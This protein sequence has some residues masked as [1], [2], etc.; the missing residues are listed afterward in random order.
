MID[1]F[2]KT[3]LNPQNDGS[4]SHLLF[5]PPGVNGIQNVK[6]L[7]EKHFGTEAHPDLM[8]L[9]N[10]QHKVDD[11]RDTRTFLQSKPFGP[12]KIMWVFFADGMNE[13]SSNAFLKS[14]EEPTPKTHIILSTDRPEKI[15]PT[16]RSRCQVT[17][18]V[19]DKKMMADEMRDHGVDDKEMKALLEQTGGHVGT[20]IALTK[21]KDAKTWAKSVHDWINNR[22]RHAKTPKI[23]TTG[24]SGLTARQCALV[25]Q[26]A[27]AK[28]LRG[29]N[30]PVVTEHFQTWI[31]NNS[32]IDRPGLDI[33]TRIQAWYSLFT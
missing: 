29:Q 19:S 8:I 4:S 6:P 30:N 10:P 23:P 18:F 14:L 12:L 26:A 11:I 28:S 17:S 20:A 1:D 21:V 27:L 31:E 3:L 9:E 13:A 25:F 32:D 7:L 2:L 22:A 33:K 15:L 16:I 5:L 24:K